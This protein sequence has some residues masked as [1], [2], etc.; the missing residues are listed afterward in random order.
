[1][2]F[3]ISLLLILITGFV[4]S[5]ST[6]PE[7]ERD[8][9]NDPESNRFIPDSPSSNNSKALIFINEQKEVVLKWPD[10]KYESGYIL[11][12]KLSD[13][14][15]YI[16]IARLDSNTTTFT[17]DS[18][19]LTLSTNYQVSSFSIKGDSLNISNSPL[20]IPLRFDSI[21][22]SNLIIKQNNQV[23]LSWEFSN[24]DSIGVRY[25]DGFLIEIN[26]SSIHGDNWEVLD[27]LKR[28]EFEN[29]SSTNLTVPSEIFDLR[30]R[31]SQLVIPNKNETHK[32]YSKTFREDYK[33]PSFVRGN[34][35]NEVDFS[36][37]WNSPFS[38]Y[39]KVIIKSWHDQ[40]ADTIKKPTL[41]YYKFT[42]YGTNNS[43][44]RFGIQLVKG[45]NFS[46]TVYMSD[47]IGFPVFVSEPEIQ[48]IEPVSET[49]MELSW[50]PY[51]GNQEGIEKK[52]YIERKELNE[53]EFSVL[54][55][56]DGSQLSY[57]DTNLDPSKTYTYKVK[58]VLS[59]YSNERNVEYKT[60]INT[61]SIEE[62]SNPGRSHQIT[63]S[64][65]FQAIIDVEDYK[66]KLTDNINN[67]T[68]SLDFNTEYLPHS[69]RYFWN[70]Y[71]LSDNDSLL[72]YTANAHRVESR[73]ILGLF[74]HRKLTMIFDSV[75]NFGLY[76]GDFAFDNDNHQFIFSTSNERTK[77]SHVNVISSINGKPVSKIKLDEYSY[78]PPNSILNIGENNLLICSYT[79]FSKLNTVTHEFELLNPTPCR[80]LKE[81]TNGSIYYLD[82]SNLY[83]YDKESET[84]EVITQIEID[85][86]FSHKNYRVFEDLNLLIFSGGPIIK[87]LK[88]NKYSFINLKILDDSRF[89]SVSL[90]KRNGS[91]FKLFTPDAIYEVEF[92]D[93]WSF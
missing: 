68:R 26:R 76:Y 4:L 3:R 82:S 5:C 9:L 38:N 41:D 86:N 21:Q 75:D 23:Q 49:T 90:I 8:N 84:S 83:K 6:G 62:L 37:N 85:L 14:S 19:E 78:T 79:G 89:P 67:I 27:T 87:D 48:R 32:I 7:F 10:A 30:L 80:F 73:Y 92:I 16:E 1:M 15:K 24:R 29:K 59:N 44:R 60:T 12:K 34:Q 58:S 25:F 42:K 36:V 17:D 51:G 56:V 22:K 81:E 50:E 72:A 46:K 71:K 93:G 69:R 54:D 45:N 70:D 91:T 28:T 20:T 31:V 11:K 64:E 88:T 77:E 43:Y 65:N 2:T 39:D 47:K 63:K 18:K 55:S 33:A 66:I 13:F 40:S 52:F 74:N 61:L 57:T 35:F 53:S